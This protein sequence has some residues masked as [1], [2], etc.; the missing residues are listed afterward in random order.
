[1]ICWL[2][3]DLVVATVIIALLLHKPGSYDPMDFDAAAYESGQVSQ[4]LTHDLSPQVYNG[5]QRGEPFD[6]VITQKGINEIVASWGWPKM[7][8]GVMLHSPAVLFTPGSALLMATAD[9]KGAE[10][11]VSIRIEPEIDPQGMLSFQV[12]QVK[13]G[14]MNVTLPAKMTARRMYAQR[15]ASLP[16][17]SEAFLTKIAESLLNGAPFE[18]VFKVDGRKVRIETITVMN[19][20]VVARLT[21]AS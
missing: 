15:V 14:A 13:I 16:I 20:R 10:F 4:Y 3:V 7:S 19:E 2:F 5:A 6:L 18:P 8:Q 17:D 21:P 9:V 1:L 12:S 11:V